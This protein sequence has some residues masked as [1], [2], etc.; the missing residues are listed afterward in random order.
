MSRCQTHETRK[1]HDTK[2]NNNNFQET[3]KI[4]ELKW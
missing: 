2:N 3:I 4:I 1:G